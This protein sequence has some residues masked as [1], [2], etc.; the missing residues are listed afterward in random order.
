MM[1]TFK[2]NE[3]GFTLIELLIA[4]PI[5]GVVGVAAGMVIIQ[6][7]QSNQI[8]HRGSAIIEAQAAGDAV[9]QDGLQA[10]TVT[11]GDDM[12]DPSWSLNLSWSGDW[13]DNT[14]A[15]HHRVANVTYTLEALGT[16]YKLERHAVITNTID[17]T[18][19]TTDVTSTVGRCLDAGQMYC[20]WQTGG[21][22][23]FDF[24]VVSTVGVKTE[25]RTYSISPRPVG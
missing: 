15:Y 21:E 14:G 22:I 2:G 8:T 16:L 13:T 6:L 12:T 20:Q 19:T 25:Q 3:K 7:V 5:I 24:K 9:S 18:T 17:G 4:I 11:F 23:T 10:Q 1:K